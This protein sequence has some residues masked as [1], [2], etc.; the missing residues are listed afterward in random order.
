MTENSKVHKKI[1]DSEKVDKIRKLYKK[2]S[3]NSENYEI[4]N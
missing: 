4:R 1:D 2:A 3:K